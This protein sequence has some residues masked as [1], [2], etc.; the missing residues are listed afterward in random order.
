[1]VYSYYLEYWSFDSG[2]NKQDMVDCEEQSMLNKRSLRWS[3]SPDTALTARAT[4]SYAMA[5][6]QMANSSIAAVPADGKV[7]RIPL[8]TPIHKRAARRSCMPI[9]NAAVSVASQA[10]SVSRV[11]P[12][13]VGSKKSS[14]ASS[15]VDHPARPG[16]R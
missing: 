15:F 5:M 7:V 2:T 9:K 12:S 8:P 3:P 1:M 10:P 11:P 4:L 6:L 13:Q 16:S 14:S